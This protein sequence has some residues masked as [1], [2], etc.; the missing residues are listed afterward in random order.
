MSLQSVDDIHG[1]DSLAASVL[2]VGDRVTDDILEEDLEHAAGLLVNETGNSLD[3]AATG[4]TADGGLSDA[5]DVVSKD[6][7]VTLG[8]S[9]AESLSSFSSSRHD[10]VV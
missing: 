4:Q 9:L 10:E 7:A 1:G 3:A 6:L 5:L 8:A 2:G